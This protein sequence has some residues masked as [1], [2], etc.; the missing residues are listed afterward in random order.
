MCAFPGA[1]LELTTRVPVPPGAPPRLTL[2][3]LALA[4]VNDGQHHGLSVAART[5]QVQDLHRTLRVQAVATAVTLALQVGLLGERGWLS[6]GGAKRVGQNHPPPPPLAFPQQ[7]GAGA[8]GAPDP[9]SRKTGCQTEEACATI[10]P[11]FSQKPTP[12][13]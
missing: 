12:S 7:G 13:L 8:E 6:W 3:G 2:A 1:W 11:S 4:A 10:N 5:A 9:R